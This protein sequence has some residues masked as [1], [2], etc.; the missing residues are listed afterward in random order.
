MSILLGD[1]FSY[2]AS[3][4]LDARLAYDTVAQMKA[5]SDSTLYA[6]I[7]AFCKADEKTY[8]WKPTNTVDATLG[9]WREF[10]GGGG[11][12]NVV[13]GYRNPVDGLFYEEAAYVTAVTGGANII[14]ID[15]PNNAPYRW[16]G[17]AFVLVGDGG[18][19]NVVEGYRN[20]ADGLFYKESSYTT[21][22]TG[23]D[24]VIYID[25]PNNTPYRW[26]GTGFVLIGSDGSD[27]VVDGYRNPANGLFYEDSAFT[28]AI[29]GADKIIYIDI[30]D[31]LP[32]RW[33]GTAFVGIYGVNGHQI[34]NA[35]NAAMTSRDALQFAG[36]LE[37]TDDSTTGAEKTVV[38]PHEMT[39]AEWAE[40]ITPIPDPVPATLGGHTIQDSDGNSMLQRE[41]LQFAGDL[42]T[43]DDST[44]ASSEKTV[45]T[46]HALTSSEFSEIITPLPGQR[47]EGIVIDERGNEYVVGEYIQADGKKKPIYERTYYIASFNS[48]IIVL[49]PSFSDQL[50]IKGSGKT[51]LGFLGVQSIPSNIC[52]IYVDNNELRVGFTESISATNLIVE[53]YYTKT[54]DTP[55]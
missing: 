34:R 26:N 38:T 7:I 8:Q 12:D 27:N 23:T 2:S 54:T 45:V 47:K 3:K 10:E 33:N 21:V 44:T 49:D 29:I 20:A 48:N 43:T 19:D 32:Y 39:S 25:L 22:I 53:A 28:T 14:Y 18:S 52:V 13:E 9:K 6:G 17:T 4:P 5:V 16:T 31:D 41:R 42:E 46:P 30:P 11:S 55:V 51:D 15:I 36:D 35:S 37:T 24:N 50:F 1:N 40:V